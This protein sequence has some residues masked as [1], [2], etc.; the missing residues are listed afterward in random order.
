MRSASIGDKKSVNLS[1]LMNK[2]YNVDDLLDEEDSSD[3]SDSKKMEN[4]NTKKISD[5]PK[6]ALDL[7][8]YQL[9]NEETERQKKATEQQHFKMQD[10]CTY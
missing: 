6:N 3:S 9:K 1:D 5:I 7:I 8:D 2:E 4:L 10:E